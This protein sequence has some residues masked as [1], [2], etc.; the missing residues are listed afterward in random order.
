MAFEP[1]WLLIWKDDIWSWYP[2]NRNILYLFAYNSKFNKLIWWW[3]SYY[4]LKCGL[5]LLN[6]D[7]T[8]IDWFERWYYVDIM[9]WWL[10]KENCLWYTT[11]MPLQILLTLVLKQILIPKSHILIIGFIYVCYFDIFRPTPS[12]L[13]YYT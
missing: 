3:C 1:I 4:D 6:L 5:E 8:K 7:V 9:S 13:K 10:W 2:W 11:L 12:S